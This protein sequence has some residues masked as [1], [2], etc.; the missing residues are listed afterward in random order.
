MDSYKIRA[1]EIVAKM[2]KAISDTNSKN[3]KECAIVCVDEVIQVLQADW[4]D[5]QWR[6][7]EYMDDWENIKKEI[8]NLPS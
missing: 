5:N 7:I 1:S 2:L 4:G 3:A 6:A 8:N